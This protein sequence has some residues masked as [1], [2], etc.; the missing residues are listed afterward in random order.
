VRCV[1]CTA[2][3][4]EAAQPCAR[5][6]APAVRHSTV[7]AD[8]PAGGGPGDSAAIVAVR[9]AGS[10]P[11]RA[12]R[13][14]FLMFLG[15][16][17]VLTISVLAAVLAIVN[18]PSNSAL[19]PWAGGVLGAA[20]PL[21]LC[22]AIA[23]FVAFVKAL[24]VRR[25]RV[26][27]VTWALVP[28]VSFSFLAWWPFLVLALIRL[29]ARDW[30]VFAVYL[31]ALVAE[32]VL[33]ILAAEKMLPPAG[34][35]EIIWVALVLL[36]AVTAAVHA[37][38]A[39]RPGVELPSFLAADQ[40]RAAAHSQQPVI[41]TT[42]GG[43]ATLPAGWFARSGMIFVT[44]ATGGIAIALPARFH[45]AHLPVR[46]VEA[47]L[48]VVAAALIWGCYRS[49]RMAFQMNDHG[50]TVCNF[51]RT[52]RIDWHEVSGFGSDPDMEGVS[53]V[54]VMRHD[55][56]TVTATTTMNTMNALPRILVAIRQEAERRG[57][58]ASATGPRSVNRRRK[59]RPKWFKWYILWWSAIMIALLIMGGGNGLV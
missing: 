53:T 38:V 24:S 11:A 54:H 20:I 32:I 12:R 43:P 39:F 5:C 25:G 48:A 18:L 36:V 1:E 7:A 26:R 50:V 17:L 3:T 40:A 45:W 22:G 13:R 16:C 51:F 35:T 15:C 56:R 10:G 55:G 49:W 46:A 28:I 52:C 58:P 29:R 2:E 21:S 27:Q 23:F 8:D 37:L 4:A 44:V 34:A 6:G 57:M 33:P 9:D 42:G 30:A 59:P 41:D 19:A 31:A 47:Y 14:Y